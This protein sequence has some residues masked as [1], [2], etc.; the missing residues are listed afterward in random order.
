MND[1][2]IYFK[3]DPIGWERI[4]RLIIR[5][6]NTTNSSRRRQ[7][8]RKIQRYGEDLSTNQL[9]IDGRVLIPN[10]LVF[11][12]CH[13]CRVASVANSI[14]QLCGIINNNYQ[15]AGFIKSIRCESDKDQE[16]SESEKEPAT[17]DTCDQVKDEIPPSCDPHEILLGI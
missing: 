15:P 4:R 2:Y 6:I 10:P 9:Y 17:P 7:L 5:D 12:P 8:K 14:P 1:G 16:K 3:I 13:E 11:H